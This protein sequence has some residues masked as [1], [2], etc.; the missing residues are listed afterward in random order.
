MRVPQTER[1]FDPADPSIYEK[2]YDFE[3]AS[4]LHE[5]AQR[6]AKEKGLGEIKLPEPGI[7]QISSR[8][9][10]VAAAYHEAMSNPEEA[11][12][13]AD[14]YAHATKHI[15]DQYAFMTRPEAE[16]GLG[17]KHEVVEEDPYA[18]AADMAKDVQDNRRIR[19]YAT[20]T[21]A[22]GGEQAPTNQAFDNSTNDMLRAVHDVFGHAATGRNFSRHGEEAAFQY[23]RSM[24]PPEA[25][26][27]M[28]SE[29][30]GQNSYL[31]YTG[32][33]EFPDPGSRMIGLPSW[34]SKDAIPTTR[35]RG[36]RR[37]PMRGQTSLEFPASE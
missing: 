11:K 1:L 24:F 5:G 12:G 16:G 32:R 14:S 35:G 9:R 10:A 21:T 29:L 22:A 13:I 6:Y 15:Q 34:A 36:R 37:G 19:T 20:A 4:F 2:P 7:G 25:H 33:N 26:A 30:R 3:P 18:S 28:T 27:A 17:I 31:N 8:G 23:H